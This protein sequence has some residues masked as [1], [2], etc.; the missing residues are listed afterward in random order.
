MQVKCE[1]KHCHIIQYESRLWSEIERHHDA[2]KQEC[3]DVLKMFKK[4]CQYLW[5]VHFVLELNANTLVAQ[6]NQIANDLSGALIM[7]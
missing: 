2:E 3:C 1:E 4:C 7:C 6:L 5:G